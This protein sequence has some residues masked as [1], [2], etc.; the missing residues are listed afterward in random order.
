MV[1]Q[2]SHDKVKKRALA[3]ILTWT[4]E[5]EN[6]PTLGIMEECYANLKGKGPVFRMNLLTVTL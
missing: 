2:N 6:D 3:L 5:F 1:P 4:T